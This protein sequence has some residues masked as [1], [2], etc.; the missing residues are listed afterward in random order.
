MVH[1]PAVP[2]AACRGHVVP[3]FTNN[4]LSLARLCDADCTATITKH[5]IT[6]YSPDGSPILTAPRDTT[7][8]RLWRAA[9]P[10]LAHHA[11]GVVTQPTPGPR[12]GAHNAVPTMVPPPS[13]LASNLRTHCQSYDLPSSRALITYL[14]ATAGY[15]VKSTWINAIK[16]GNYN[17]WPGLTPALAARYCPDADE[18]RRGH[19]AQ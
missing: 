17:T 16:Q 5:A 3:G 1:L 14:H 11:C 8:P 10:H 2:A 4:L 7:G 13:P 18:T 12:L 9:L 6:V 19:M 15:P